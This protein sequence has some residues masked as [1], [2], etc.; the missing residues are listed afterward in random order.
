MP[1]QAE[2]E[3]E[4]QR[5]MDLCDQASLVYI[6]SSRTVKALK[7]GPV[8]KTTPPPKEIRDWRDGSMVKSTDCFPEDS[9]SIPSTYM[10]AHNC[11]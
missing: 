11:L 6:K 8:S 3:A 4:R 2:A 7:R 1:R 9:G 10:V 5:Q